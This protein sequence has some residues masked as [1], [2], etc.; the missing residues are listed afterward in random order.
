MEKISQE[1]KPVLIVSP[2]FPPRK[3][4]V[5]DHTFRLA[6]ALKDKFRVR[7][8]TSK[9]CDEV[10]DFQVFP[11]VYDWHETEEL[12]N[13]ILYL[14]KKCRVIWQYVPHMYGR[15]GVNK[16]IAEVVEMLSETRTRQMMIA[17]EIFAPMNWLPNRAMYALSQRSQWKR[18]S[19][20]MERIGVSTQAWI[21]RGWGVTRNNQDAYEFCPSPSGIPFVEVEKN[22]KDNWK[23]DHG[24]SPDA[25]VIGFFG[26]PGPGK[27]FDWV[28]DAWIDAQDSSKEVALVCIGKE[29]DFEPDSSLKPLYVPTG[30][31]DPKDVSRA[32]QVVD[33]MALP[34][35]AG[36]SEKRTS[37]TGSLQHGIPVVTIHGEETS[38]QLRQS[39]AFISGE[40]GD[41]DEFCDLV[42]NL[43]QD[44]SKREALRPLA[45]SHYENNFSW[46][47]VAGKVEYWIKHPRK[48]RFK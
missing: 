34:F 28:V 30:Y 47:I 19:R 21:D 32:L 41:R 16:E 12:Y 42:S 22:H 25:I 38:D 46:D 18:I 31:L 35:E 36:V 8:L 9:H 14:S 7:V 17:H 33:V 40:A 29:P 26:I 5:S 4:G 20:H 10:D 44:D 39:E 48:V 43:V 23:T 45:S 24:L 6:M 3:G 11:A 15:G 13:Q 27:Q 2:D 37:F 1:E